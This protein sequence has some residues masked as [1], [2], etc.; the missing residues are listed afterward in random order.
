[1]IR[2]QRWAD[3]ATRSSCSAI[4]PESVRMSISWVYPTIADSGLFSSWATPARSW[5]IAATF[6]AW[7]S[8]ARCASSLAVWARSAS[9]RT[10][11]P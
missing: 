3:C 5:P 2:V 7:N 4:G 11:R 10:C 9:S 1:M 6:S 8:A